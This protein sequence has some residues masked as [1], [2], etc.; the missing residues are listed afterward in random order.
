MTTQQMDEV[1]QLPVI[2]PQDLTVL[3]GRSSDDSAVVLSD[4]D[5][6]RLHGGWEVS[7]SLY[8]YSGRAL[9]RGVLADWLLVLKIVRPSP[10][11]DNPA[12]WNYWRREPLAYQ[13]GLL[14]ALPAGLK[15]P[16]CY[17]IVEQADQ[18][19]PTRL[20]R[21]G[22]PTV[23]GRPACGLGPLAGIHTGPDC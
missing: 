3:V 11:R 18:R 4:W 17:A 21:T 19:K 1:E 9:S 2:D 10:E 12:H 15:A 6:H 8:R 16:R 22:R 13:S 14:A 23:S 5:V 20:G 7:S